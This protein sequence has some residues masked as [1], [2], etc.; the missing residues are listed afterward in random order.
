LDCVGRNGGGR[1]GDPVDNLMGFRIAMETISG[2][3]C[4]K[5]D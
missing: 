5:L 2:H 4:E 3:V 1:A